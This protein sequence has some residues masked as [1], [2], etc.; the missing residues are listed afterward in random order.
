MLNCPRHP[1][2]E[3]SHFC[4]GSLFWPRHQRRICSGCPRSLTRSLPHCKEILEN[5]S[6]SNSNSLESERSKTFK[7]WLSDLVFPWENHGVFKRKPWENH[8]EL[9]K[10]H[11]CGFLNQSRELI[12]KILPRDPTIPTIGQKP[13]RKRF[14]W[15][16][17]YQLYHLVM[18]NIAMENPLYLNLSYKWRF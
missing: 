2:H 3:S 17:K 12:D 15:T 18:T 6:A 9:Q 10:Y 7:T 8:G 13:T 4:T 5:V 1:T 11:G 14:R 16:P